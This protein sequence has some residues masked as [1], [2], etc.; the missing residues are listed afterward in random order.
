MDRGGNVAYSWPFDLE[1]LFGNAKAKGFSGDVRLQNF[2]P[3]GLQLLDDGTL[4]ATFHSRNI[5]PYT[6]GIAHI[7]RKG[8]ILWKQL[9]YSHH[10]FRVA[11][12]GM[13]YSPVQFQVKD[14]KVFPGTKI[15]AE[16]DLPVYLDGIRVRRPDGTVVRTISILDALVK[17]GYRGLVY[18]TRDGCDPTHLNSIDIVTPDIATKIPGVAPGDLLV[19]IREFSAVAILD[20]VDGHVKKLV[21]G[22]TSAQHSAYFLPDGRV[23]VFDNRGA[24]P[25]TGGTRIAV[26]DFNSGETQTVFPRENGKALLPFY[27]SMAGHVVPSP[28]SKRLMVTDSDSDRPR[29]FEI[30]LETG[31]PLWMMTEAHDIAPFMT[32]E[33]NPKP[34]KMKF[35]PYGA[36]YLS[37]IQAQSLGLDTYLQQ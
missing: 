26:I 8:E 25:E 28:D 21:S 31:K 13:I 32:D 12:D 16:C 6:V 10:W 23:V 19:S 30:D 9:D 1:G 34:I 15:K 5:Y 14:L 3:I 4:L 11:Q 18:G 7:G 2:F 24:S 22:Q 33:A 27:T 20:S 35:N 17:S 29:Y 37:P 36:Y